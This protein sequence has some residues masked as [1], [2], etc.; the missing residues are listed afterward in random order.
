[1]TSGHAVVGELKN[2]V[3]AITKVN[4]KTGKLYLYD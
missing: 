3:V 1:M 2:H 4:V